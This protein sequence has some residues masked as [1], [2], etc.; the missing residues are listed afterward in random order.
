M[1]V[2]IEQPGRQHCIVEVVSY[3]RR[4]LPVPRQSTQSCCHRMQ[5][6]LEISVAVRRRLT[7]TVLTCV[8]RA[9]RIGNSTLLCACDI[10]ASIQVRE[11]HWVI[12]DLHGKVGHIRTV[13]ISLWV[14]EALD[15]WTEASQI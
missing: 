14:K 2:N 8:D 5:A 1:H 4:L 11:E 10:P 7:L 15:R 12:A 3:L 13:P 9:N 6:L